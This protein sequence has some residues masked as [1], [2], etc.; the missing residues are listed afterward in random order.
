MKVSNVLVV[1]AVC[2]FVSGC[3]S[4]PTGLIDRLHE[5]SA[6]DLFVSDSEE[7]DG[8]VMTTSGGSTQEAGLRVRK[9]E[10]GNME[11]YVVRGERYF[12]LD[13]ADGYSARGIASW[14]GPNFHG[15]TAS[16]GEVYDM[17]RLTACLLYTS[18]SPRD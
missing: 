4:M 1:G 3:S 8:D 11:S 6:K 15:R 7:I 12:T 9:S 17:Y 16:N 10:R 5:S 13:S 14:Y 2:A 18:P